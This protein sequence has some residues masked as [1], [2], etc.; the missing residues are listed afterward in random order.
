MKE[1][2]CPFSNAHGQASQVNPKCNSELSLI[3]VDEVE[4]GGE[5]SGLGSDEAAANDDPKSKCR[6]MEAPTIDAN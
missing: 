5:Q 1:K 2:V 6:E 4:V 3:F